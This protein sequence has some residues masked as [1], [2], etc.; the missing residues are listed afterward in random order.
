MIENMT[1]RSTVHEVLIAVFQVRT[2]DAGHGPELAPG[3]GGRG[4]LAAL[5]PQRRAV[6]VERE[7]HLAQRVG[8]SLVLHKASEKE[9]GGGKPDA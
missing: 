8:D 7:A 9:S 1:H 3:D 5:D 4:G 6:E 2:F